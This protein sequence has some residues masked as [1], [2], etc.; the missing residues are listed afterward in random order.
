MSEPMTKD[1]GDEIIRLLERIEERLESIKDNTSLL[2][3][4]AGDL[5][6]IRHDVLEISIKD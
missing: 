6:R 1:Q 4:I 3:P 2:S 5:E